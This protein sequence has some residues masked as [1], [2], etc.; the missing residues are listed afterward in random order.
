MSYPIDFWIAFASSIICVLCSLLVLYC[1]LFYRTL[2]SALSNH[3]IILLLILIII[4]TLEFLGTTFYGFASDQFMLP[5][6]FSFLFSY[7]CDYGLYSIQ[8]ILVLWANIERHILIFHNQWISTKK[9]RFY[10]HYMPPMLLLIY[11]LLF[12]ILIT[13]NPFC[14]SSQLNFVPGIPPSPCAL[15]NAIIATVDILLHHIIVIL[16]IAILSIA[17]IVRVILQK[18]R[19]NQPIQW[20][21]HRRMM[22]QM[23][24]TS[25][26]YLICDAPWAIL[27]FIVKNN[28]LQYNLDTPLIVALTLRNYVMYLYP[29]I[30]LASLSELRSKMKDT[31]LCWRHRSQVVPLRTITIEPRIGRTILGTQPV[32]HLS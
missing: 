11:S 15:N 27:V 6:G 12:Y 28:L 1:L 5:L 24:F 7:F 19:L 3:I 4:R 13:F 31:F 23:I 2:R 18:Q 21:K 17:L 29:F 14:D 10:V 32:A 22:I 26:F 25:I 9:K 16:L 30:C 20:Q 8:I